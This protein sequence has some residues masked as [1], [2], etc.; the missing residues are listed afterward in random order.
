MKIEKNIP[1]APHSHHRYGK[2]AK[3]AL[4][5]EDGDSVLCTKKEAHCLRQAIYK[6]CKGYR[7][8]MRVNEEKRKYEH[9]KY[10]V[11]KL[12]NDEERN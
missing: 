12:K 11:W 7:P 4:D 5:M 3:I 8:I 10:R 2:Y 1:L 6:Y 9:H